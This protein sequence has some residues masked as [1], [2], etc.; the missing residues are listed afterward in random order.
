MIHEL[1]DL[2]HRA[3]ARLRSLRLWTS[4]ALCWS[5]WAAIVYFVARFGAPRVENWG[6]VWSVLIVGALLTALVCWLAARRAGRDPRRIARRIE[7]THPELGAMLLAA[8]EQ[9]PSPR[10]KRLGYLQAAV[11]RGAVNHGRQHDWGDATSRGRLALAKTAH[12]ASFVA[13]A[14]ACVFLADR[15][16]AHGRSRP[17]TGGG[18]EPILGADYEVEVQP[19]DAEIERGTTLLVIAKFHGPLPPDVDLAVQLEKPLAQAADG[20][21]EAASDDDK[22]DAQS[23]RR[24]TRSLDDPQFVGR[25]PAVTRPLDY[26]VSFAGRQSPMYHVKV[27]EY[28]ELVR[29]DARLKYPQYT[30]LEEKVVEDVRQVTAVEGTE[31]TLSF[32]LNKDVADARLVDRDGEVVALAHA[33]GAD[34]VYEV[35]Y[36][37]ERSQRFKLHLVDREERK[38]KLPPDIV[39]NVTPNNPPT[40]KLTKPGR[41]VRVSPVEELRVAG[42]MGDDFGVTGYGISYALGGDEPTDIVLRAAKAPVGEASGD[43]A[44][45]AAPTP[46]ATKAT[47]EHLIDFE[48][49]NAKPDQLVSYHVWVEDVGPDGQPRRTLSDMFFAEVRHFD[50][51]FR[52]GEQQ[53]QQQQHEQQQQQQGQQGAGQQAEELAELQ[54]QVVSATWK[55]IRRETGKEPTAAFADDS[56]AVHDGQQAAFDKLAELGEQL[57]DLQSKEYLEQTQQFMERALELLG[58][59]AENDLTAIRPALSPEQAAYQALLKLRAREFNVTRQQAG[60]QS[61]GSASGAGSA[62]QQQLQQL[63]LSNDENRYETQ[64]RAAANQQANSAQLDESRQIL[65]RLRELARRQQDLNQRLRELQ[66]S[67]EKAETPQ[68]REDIERQLKRLRDQQREI[69]RD[70]EAL[71]NDM[72]NSENRQQMQDAS[73]QLSQTR[74]RVQQASESL[75]QGQ[76]SQALTEG[77]RAEEELNTLRDDFRRKTADRFND[78]MRQLRDAVRQLDER[79]QK[80]SKQLDDMNSDAHRSLRDTGP[81][82]EYLDGMQQQKRELGETLDRIRDTVT[83]A[84]TPEPL[85]AG[86]LFKAVQQVGEQRTEESLEVAR[87]LT[88]AGAASEAGE[89]MRQANRGVQQLRE[90]IDRA[91]ESVLGDEAEA[92]RRADERLRDLADALNREIAQGRGDPQQSGEGEQN[93]SGEERQ[94]Q[95]QQG[96]GEQ[97]QEGQ[98]GQAGAQGG[99]RRQGAQAGQ[100]SGDEREAQGQQPGQGE[101][102]QGQHDGQRQAQGQQG[103]GQQA[104][105]PTRQGGGRGQRQ[106][107]GQRSGQRPGGQQGEQGQAGEPNEQG[108][109]Q[110]AAEGEQASQEQ[111]QG[112]GQ[113]P[114]E[115]PGEGQQGQRGQQGRQGQRGQG[116]G[117]QGAG[118][119]GDGEQNDQQPQAGDAGEQQNAADDSQQGEP[120]AADGQAGQNGGGRRNGSPN[121]RD[122][123]GAR[124][125][126]PGGGGGIDNLGQFEDAFNGAENVRGPITGDGFRQWS[127]GMREVQDMLDDP[128]M[129]AEAARIRDRAEA[130][131]VDYV[132]HSKTPD[133]NKLQDMVAQPLAEL[134]EKI[135]DEIRRKESPDALAPIDRDAAP[136]E[137]AEEVRLYYQRLGSGE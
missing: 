41:D 82:Q 7:A 2:L 88:E 107:R 15:T 66:A 89:A 79:Q 13:L 102:E 30:R 17:T 109:Q 43:G 135:N 63:E 93:P 81:R 58:K 69:L 106:G 70:T 134:R 125:N 52:Q 23:T 65:N 49:L 111:Q 51:I 24:M 53:T 71:D 21:G 108:D 97:G 74:E 123:G 28:P 26:H 126:G 8:L 67:L 130:A 116:Q 132:R 68:E 25:V 5:F 29:T 122:A 73:G 44:A 87:Q 1:H 9:A 118:G 55:L 37:L 136:P 127:E 124:R 31:L 110:Q 64:S 40:I 86:Q 56:V 137:Y 91:A 19:G 34:P 113:Q 12:F 103:E 100:G 131:R 83:E 120:Q 20:N 101:G 54:K 22:A 47:L 75:E 3:G 84:E 92:L 76:V 11:V 4:L 114:G 45:A 78:E 62:S 117:G 99:G 46:A 16:A 42:E 50:E 119:R 129:S 133:W 18:E 90:Q 104:G 94:A 60:Q 96:E 85:L 32:R 77:A 98:D 105:E 59:A 10:F 36:K 80:L 112:A 38:N 95:G 128:D 121:N 57:S 61:S 48:S 27:F 33:Q 39:V 35:H 14:A 6:Q 115:N 72:Q